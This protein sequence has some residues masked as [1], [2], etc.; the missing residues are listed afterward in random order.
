MTNLKAFAL[1]LG[2]S[3]L[4]IPVH[5]QAP[6]AQAQHVP[7]AGRGEQLAKRWCA[8]CHLVAPGQQ[9][10]MEA[11]PFETVARSQTYTPQS[12]AFFLLDPHP[13]MPNMSLTRAEA[14]DL[15]AYIVSLRK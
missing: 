8:G 12:L 3:L 7:D 6:R 9:R 5:A 13:K 15:A 10:T 2:L 14:S 11:P 4:S 1:G